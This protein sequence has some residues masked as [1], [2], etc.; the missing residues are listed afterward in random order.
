MEME[1]TEY[2]GENCIQKQKKNMIKN[3]IRAYNFNKR[4][5]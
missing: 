3:I 4:H 2:K 5:V 1:Y